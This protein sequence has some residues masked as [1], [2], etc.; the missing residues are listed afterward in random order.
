LLAAAEAATRLMYLHPG[1]R[2]RARF[3]DLDR[4]STNLLLNP[5]RRQQDEE[6]GVNLNVLSEIEYPH[7]LMIA[8]AIL[9]VFGFI[10]Y[11]FVK[12]RDA[13]HSSETSRVRA[14]ID[15]ETGQ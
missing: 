3:H 13:D 9:V 11:I 7:W 4:A 12:N 2:R 5:I 8:G 15:E 6:E 1:H 10:G 14:D